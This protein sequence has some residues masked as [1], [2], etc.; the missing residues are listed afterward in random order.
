MRD[1]LFK[2]CLV[3][4]ICCL[5][6][7]G[8]YKYTEYHDAKMRKDL[9]ESSRI[10]V[11]VQRATDTDAE[12]SSTDASVIE[13][14]NQDFAIEYV[15]GDVTPDEVTTYQ[16]V[17]EIP[18]YNIIARVNEGVEKESLYGGVGHYPTTPWIGEKGNCT[19]AGHYS[20]T[21][22]CV[23]NG[24]ENMK[25]LDTWYAYDKDGNKHE[26]TCIGVSIVM[27][28][29]IG[30]VGAGD[31]NEY[32]MT[33]TTCSDNGTRRRIITGIEFTS[34]EQR[35]YYTKSIE[36]FQVDKA[37]ELNYD[38]NYYK[39]LKSVIKYPSSVTYGVA[40]VDKRG[41]GSI[42]VDTIKPY[43]LNDSKISER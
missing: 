38:I 26:Y 17:I 31:D 2:I 13:V 20:A 39:E 23:F 29:E 4:C 12:E 42:S 22:N 24:L 40:P 18:Q 35:E 25:P 33:L 11:D 32:R 15:D 34:D 37:L 21:Y 6:V 9:V 43:M 41:D 8:V 3:V 7:L 1:V 16:N 5:V 10:T 28:D 14:G 30:I 19:I 27:P 36:K